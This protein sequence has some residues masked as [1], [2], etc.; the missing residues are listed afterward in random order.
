MTEVPPVRRAS[1]VFTIHERQQIT[2][3]ADSLTKAGH[4]DAAELLKEGLKHTEQTPQVVV[5]GEVKRGKSTLVNA[6]AGQQV[7][8]MGID[9]VTFCPLSAT[10]PTQARP[11]GTGNLVYR[12]RTVGPVMPVSELLPRLDPADPTPVGPQGRPGGAVVAVDQ[13]WLGGVTRVDTPGV[14]GLHSAHGRT[15]LDA[16]KK[17]GALLFVSDAGQPLT[18]P[19]LDFLRDAAQATEF[20]VF[21]LAKVDLAAGWDEILA[22]NRALLREHAPRFAG[23]P[24]YPVAAALALESW[25]LGADDAAFL[26]EASRIGRLA[27]GLQKVATNRN[28]V[29]A[30]NAIRAGLSGLDG[31]EAS[32][33]CQLAALQDKA[34]V[35]TLEDEQTRLTDFKDRK[36]YATRTDIPAEIGRLRREAISQ[37]NDG[38]DGITQRLTVRISAMRG[39]ATAEQLFEAEVEA[40]M[41]ALVALVRDT[42]ADGLEHITAGAFT[43]LPEPNG[44]LVLESV[45]AHPAMGAVRARRRTLPGESTLMTAAGMASMGVMALRMA[46]MMDPFAL[47]AGAAMAF[48]VAGR[49][50][51]ALQQQLTANLTDSL[52]ALRRD[53]TTAIDGALDEFRPRLYRALEGQLTRSIDELQKIIASATA[54]ASRRATETNN[55]ERRRE[56]VAAEREQLAAILQRVNTLAAGTSAG[57]AASK[58]Q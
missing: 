37:V 19:E 29:H 17:A 26:I 44:L 22:E 5:V 20:V 15:T 41:S 4:D 35:V 33:A 46:T 55:L 50:K 1:Q 13:T 45:Y 2:R 56:Q 31:S 9:V 14:G 28:A 32:I 40:E 48:T 6:L 10:P 57:A 12:D 52:A 3:I 38:C 58:D 21:A 43:G 16:V 54:D 7:T 25:D 23:A 34:V 30:A 8:P 47:I 24:I 51:R 11:V 27:D 18:K 49:G 42:M 36:Q 53:T 39:S